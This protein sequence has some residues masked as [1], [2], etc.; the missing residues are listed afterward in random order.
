MKTLVLAGG[1]GT[2]LRPLSCSRPKALF[3]IAN[4]PLID[5]T[6]ESLSGAGTETVILAV[7]Y[8]AESLVRYLGPTKYN[9]GILYS[10]EQRPLGTA[11]PIKKAKDMLNGEAFMV[12]NG[13]ILTEL[14]YKQLIN[15]H[16]EKGGIA[17][18]AL[19]QVND[20]Y[21]YGSV[22]MDWEGRITRFVEK[23][24]LGMA[25]SNLVNAGVYIL[26]PE[27]FDYIPE[28]SK[29]RIETEVFPKLAEEQQ[30]YGFET[31][32]FWMDI[33][34]P[35]DYIEANAAILARQRRVMKPDS[36]EIDSLA[37]INGT[38]NFGENVKI[39][40]DSRIGP[41]VSLADDVVIGK[42]CR[43]ENSIIYSGAVIEDYSS[44]K[45]AILGENS[46]L[47]RWVKVESGS[48]I[49]DFA[50]ISDGVTITSGVSVCP[51]KTVEES[52]LQPKQ[53]M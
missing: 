22:E 8:M 34:E 51:S 4:K 27:I 50:Q 3:P 38:C 29:S 23:P 40:A 28:G 42:G 21:R 1:F 37:I 15:Y 45:N 47:E 17:T 52:I 5:Y 26:E 13:D 46:V 7:Y 20:P 24:E 33:G 43:V 30:L 39:G 11:G 25:P 19:T 18:V 31:H 32:A 12:M 6:L 35:V 2:R 41:N 9:L 44:V 16:E 36:V 10:R 14:D 48:L 53:V 49:G